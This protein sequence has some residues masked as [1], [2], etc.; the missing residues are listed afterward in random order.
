MLDRKSECC[1]VP[2]KPGNQTRG[3]QRREGGTG[4][5]RNRLEDRWERLCAHKPSQRNANG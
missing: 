2:K 5:S 4:R 3:T 1:I